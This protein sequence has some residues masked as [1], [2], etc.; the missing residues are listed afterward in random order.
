MITSALEMYKYFLDGM[1]KEK[2]TTVTPDEFNR[3][4]NVCEV[5][6][7]KN[8]YSEFELTEKRIDDLRILEIRDVI[9]NTGT[10]APGD[11]IFILPYNAVTNVNTPGNP[12]GT[13]HGYMFMLNV[14]WKIQYINNECCED[15]VSKW[16]PSR[17]MKANFEWEIQD[18][19]Y[20]KPQD[21]RLFHKIIGNQLELYTGTESYGLEC[22]ID[23]LRYPRM[24][25]VP[26]PSLP[27]DV[28]SELPLHTREEIISI[29]I[30]KEL[31]RIESP[32]YQQQLV[33]NS[34]TIT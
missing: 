5:E 21:N 4:I 28:T 15:S 1:N 24:I 31:G 6:W 12:S 9:P 25:N 2:T 8:K 30:R 19:P 22:R 16:I 13:N 20:N 7:I 18:D 27:I 33:E 34:Q 29:A 14:A 11:E 32:R 3:L 10:P 23:Y 17:T 26:T